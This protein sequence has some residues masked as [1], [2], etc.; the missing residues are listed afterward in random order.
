LI[1]TETHIPESANAIIARIEREENSIPNQLA[2]IGYI[3]LSRA[4]QYLYLNY[5][6]NREA[7]AIIEAALTEVQRDVHIKSVR[8]ILDYILYTIDWKSREAR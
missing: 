1:Q 2:V 4:A 5:Q 7:V 8:A 6:E 3:K